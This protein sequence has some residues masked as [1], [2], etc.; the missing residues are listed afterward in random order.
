MEFIVYS[1]FNLKPVILKDFKRF[2]NYMNK[3]LF[4]KTMKDVRNHRD[5]K[6]IAIKPRRNYL[7]PEPNCSTTKFLIY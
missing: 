5:N 6:L 1:I 7:V 2:F 4:R 3:I